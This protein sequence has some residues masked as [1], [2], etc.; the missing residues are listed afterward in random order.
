MDLVYYDPPYNKHP[1]SIYY[2]LLDIINNWDIHQNIP[3]TLRGQP[4]TW[5]K[6]MYNSIPKARDIFKELIE[7]TNAKF[8][9][10]SYNNAGIIKDMGAILSSKGKVTK[11]CFSHKTYNKMNGIANF[12]REKA[13]L[14]IKEN[15]WLVDCRPV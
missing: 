15:L 9:L 11:Y 14:N 5:K 13:I 12:K 2:F 10:V 3:P 8:I 6:S 7:H 1:Y 4:K